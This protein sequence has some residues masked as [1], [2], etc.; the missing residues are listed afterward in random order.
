[1]TI[2]QKRLLKF[3]IRVLGVIILIVIIALFLYYHFYFKKDNLMK[4][5][6][7]DATVYATFRLTEQIKEK[8]FINNFF[9][10]LEQDMD[11]SDPDFNLLNNFVGYNSAFALIPHTE[12][13]DL[14]FDYLLI[15]NLKKGVQ[16]PAYYLDNLKEHG[17]YY[18]TLNV[19]ALER[20]IL[21][22]SNS[23]KV[24]QEAK[25][26]ANQESPCLVDKVSVVLNLNKLDLDY[27][28][29][30]YINLKAIHDF[31]PM[32]KDLPT[33]LLLLSLSQEKADQLFL[34]IK[35]NQDNI[36]IESL[37]GDL[38]NKPLL[39][40]NLPA[41]FLFSFRF[42]SGQQKI[43]D[44]Y[45]MLQQIDFAYYEQLAQKKQVLESIYGFDLENEL[46][47]FLN[48]QA[49]L[50]GL[51][52]NNYLLAIQLDQ[53]TDVPDKLAN[54]EQV[55]RGYLAVKYPIEEQKQLPD[56]TYITQIVKNPNVPD[57]TSE[58]FYNFN[59]RVIKFQND[60][61]AYFY[62]D[63]VIF[64]SNSSDKIKET[65]AGQNLVNLTQSITCFNNKM[66]NL[67]Q[68]LFIKTEYLTKFWS[69][70]KY[71][72][73]ILINE[74]LANDKAIWLCLE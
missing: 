65:V 30:L 15:F 64:L 22:V 73:G 66:P 4:Y 54:L 7:Q 69:G 6:P 40:T 46:L 59:L 12:Q 16:V 27:T 56:Y 8:P 47:A 32:I 3:C 35:L 18:D 33:K 26:T 2:W 34:G 20:N 19:K 74:D 52:N 44:L 36:V 25:N 23:A 11:F 17:F 58:I 37:I 71:L 21:L 1:M 31:G 24:L 29:K 55:I 61:F 63:D 41:D 70:F 51:E 48:G 14:K 57:F 28:G 67:S 42:F 45:E 60:E 38:P 10:N 49:Q 43:N 68:N 5:V 53:I 13:Q 39:M 9:K 50:V 72:K 62:T